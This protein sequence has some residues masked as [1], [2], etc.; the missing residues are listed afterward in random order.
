[1]HLKIK[2]LIQSGI[3]L[4]YVSFRGKI[5]VNNTKLMLKLVGRNRT[6]N[7]VVLMEGF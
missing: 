3:G 4:N 7:E 1:M 2:V 5:G 6:S